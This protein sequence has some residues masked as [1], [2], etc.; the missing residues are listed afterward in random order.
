[1]SRVKSCFAVACLTIFALSPTR[2]QTSSATASEH[3]PYSFSNFPWWSDSELREVLKQRIP[4]LTDE[5]SRSS[6]AEGK[7]R[8]VLKQILKEKGIQAE[9][10]S[11]EPSLDVFKQTRVPEAPAPSII[12]ELAAPT[13]IVIENLVL[14][15]PPADAGLALTDVTAT[16]KGRPYSEGVFWSISQNV[17]QALQQVGYLSSMVEM[18]HDP[19]H[20]DG[21]SYLVPLIAKIES[22]PKYHVA[23][24][25]GD[26][27]PLLAGRDLSPYFSLKKGDVATPSA[28]GRLYGSLRS[29]YWRA[30]YADVEF[31]GDPIIDKEHA[32]D[33]FHG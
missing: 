16:L 2:A 9:V 27:G 23:A 12:F 5:I 28:F 4:G 15:N 33:H 3:F 14:D 8:I 13:K 22:G 17:R 25:T 31:K 24:V 32:L 30:G 18:D 11:E 20:K 10:Q 1:L 19:S 29:M 26:G 7:I 21:E 6:N